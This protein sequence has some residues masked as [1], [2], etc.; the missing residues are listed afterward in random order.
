MASFPVSVKTFATRSAGQ[1]IG[2]AHVNDLQDEVNAIEDN[3]VNGLQ[4][5]LTARGF[6]TSTGR[7]NIGGASTLT[8]LQAGASTLTTLQVTGASTLATLQVTGASTLTG[9]V[10]I[11]GT[12][13][14]GGQQVG[15][16]TY[17]QLSHSVRQ[18]FN[19]AV[20]AGLNWDTEDADAS[21]L[22][23]TAANSSRITFGSTGGWMVGCNLPWSSN[24]APGVSVGRI[25]LND[26]ENTL[27]VSGEASSR[28]SAQRPLSLS[29]LLR[30]A[31]ASDYATVQ[32]FT[33]SGSTAGIESVST[34][35]GHARF[36]AHRI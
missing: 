6:T 32:V 31:S 33:N 10:T 3:L 7:L 22:H 18:E 14:V 29:G 15:A 30:V 34:L 16:G 36:W 19:Q 8:T 4:L 17:V 23:S 2:S 12:L 9:N 27:I 26:N 11:T 5:V 25:V 24:A 35:Y 1:T 13:T 28:A 21:A 20:W